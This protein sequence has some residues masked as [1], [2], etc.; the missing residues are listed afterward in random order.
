MAHLMPSLSSLRS[1]LS[2]FLTI[3]QAKEIVLFERN[4]F[5]VIS[6]VTASSSSSAITSSGL[7]EIED[8]SGGKDKEN[9]EMEGGEKEGEGEGEE[10]WDKR[11][12]ERVSTMVKAFKLGCTHVL[13]SSFYLFSLRDSYTNID[14]VWF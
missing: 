12:F 8:N 6:S 10:E 3:T 1:H 9:V 7:K 4:T 11:R 14:S 5:L 13:F 2:Q